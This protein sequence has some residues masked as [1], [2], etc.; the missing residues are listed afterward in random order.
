[1]SQ[2]AP[3]NL[4]YFGT[5]EFQSRERRTTVYRK[6]ILSGIVVNKTTSLRVYCLLRNA[7]I[8]YDFVYPPASINTSIT[9]RNRY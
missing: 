4:A 2:V 9:G 7:H 8:G 5:P 3:T 1:M 6:Q